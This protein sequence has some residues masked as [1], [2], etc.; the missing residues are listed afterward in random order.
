M[1][2]RI[3]HA[4]TLTLPSDREIVLSRVFNAPRH[5]VFDAWTKPEHMKHWYGCSFATLRACEIDLRPGGAYR[6]VMQAN[7]ADHTMRGIYREIARPDRLVYTEGYVTEG[8]ASNE[9]LVTVTFVERDGK[10]TLTSTILHGSIEDR[11][12]H[13]KSGM[14]HGAA[15][16]LDRLEEHLPTMERT[17]QSNA[18]LMFNGQCEAAFKFYEKVLGGKIEAMIPHEGSPAATSVPADWAKKIMHARLSVGGK[19]FLMAS[20][21]PPQYSEPM[22]GFQVNISI[23]DPAEADRVFNALAEGGTVRM[24]IQKTFWAIRF[25]MLTDRFGTPWM[26]NCEQPQ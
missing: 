18:Y 5:L 20:D 8:F 26:V 25:G 2:A 10:T 19:V 4:M 9:A 14:E 3:K 17:M 21:A 11:D 6:F 7:G 16:T 24:P 23:D 1:D 15:E 22:K 13:L 12:A